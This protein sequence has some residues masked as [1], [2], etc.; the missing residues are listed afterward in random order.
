MLHAIPWAEIALLVHVVVVAILL[1]RVLY[2]QHDTGVAMAWIVLLF[3]VPLVGALGYL[4]IGEPRLGTARLR[5]QKELVAFYQNFSQLYLHNINRH[6]CYGLNER[7]HGI[8]LIAADKTGFEATEGNQ[9]QLLDTD[10]DIIKSIRRDI[11]NAKSSCLLAFYII[12]AQGSI[13]DLLHDLLAAA[14]RGVVTSIL[15]DSVGSAHF[16]RGKW[17]QKLRSAGVTVTEALPVGLWRTLFV[18]ADLRNHRKIVVIDQ[19]IGY[20]GSFN[21]VDP[22]FFKQNA[23]VGEW[24]DVMMRCEGSLVQALAAIFAADLGVENDQNLL[25]VQ[26]WLFKYGQE[27]LADNLNTANR[28]NNDGGAVVQVIPS[29]PEQ[30]SPV[31]YD[32]IV[33]AIHAAT[34]RILITTPYFVPDDALLL[35]LTTAAERGVDVTL[36]VP[37]AVDSLLVRYASRAYYPALLRAGV[38]IA[39]FE[40][41]LL[42][43]KTLT[44]DHEYTLFGTVNMDMRSFYLNMEISLAIYDR[45]RTEK[46]VAL[47]NRYLQN[48]VYVEL[49]RWQ[50][51][52]KWWTLIENTVR[53]FGPLL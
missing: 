52:S 4:L 50:Q 49:K 43:A 15:A 13:E 18:R 12:D 1:I 44:I 35:A 24:V 3:T 33:N 53:L 26:Q 25:M 41:G 34:R 32:T 17:P 48:C 5:R 22:R 46:I 7:Y 10:A 51:R 40:G 9:L 8:S 14:Q 47:Q 11:Q 27:A 42:H 28:T 29:A 45:D 20:T 31:I 39:L 36:I 2:H 23:G 19:K 16:L 37:K 21:L 38:K 30:G 6:V